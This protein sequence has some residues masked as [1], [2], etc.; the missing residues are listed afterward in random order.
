MA[1]RKQR[2]ALFIQEAPWKYVKFALITLGRISPFSNQQLA[3][4]TFNLIDYLTRGDLQN[5]SGNRRLVLLLFFTPIV[6][7]E[8]VSVEEIELLHSTESES[9]TIFMRESVAK[10]ALDIILYIKRYCD[11]TPIIWRLFESRSKI[12]FFFF[13]FVI[14]SFSW[15]FFLYQLHVLNTFF[16]IKNSQIK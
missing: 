9:S 2:R 1:K 6:S 12:F 3:I 14:L 7:D 16:V 5:D 15:S 13:T 4:K 11:I 8:S 10:N